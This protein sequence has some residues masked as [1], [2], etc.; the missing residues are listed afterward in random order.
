MGVSENVDI[1]VNADSIAA[2]KLFLDLVEGF[3]AIGGASQRSSSNIGNAFSKAASDVGKFTLGM[4]GAQSVTQILSTAV[5]R[6]NA[7]WDNFIQRADKAATSQTKFADAERQMANVLGDM[8]RKQAGERAISI[9]RKSGIDPY[10]VAI[11]ASSALSGKGE[12][13]P[14][15]YAF[16]AIQEAAEYM[17]G[18]R[19]QA[20]SLSG[21]ASAIL[22]VQKDDPTLSSKEAMA[23]ISNVMRADRSEKI[24][25]LSTY[26]LPSI[27]RARGYGSGKDDLSFLASMGTAIGQRA[28]DPTGQTTST[29]MEVFLKQV[30]L[31]TLPHVG[32]D[33]SVKQQYD[34]LMDTNEGRKIR[35]ELL[36]GL[37]GGSAPAELK[38]ESS[39]ASQI[40][41]KLLG[42]DVDL[43][44]G[45]GRML[46]PLT[47]LLQD[48]DNLTKRTFRANLQSIPSPHDP[49]NLTAYQR[50]QQENATNV[51]QQTANLEQA[52]SG[53]QGT[54]TL[55][56]DVLGARGQFRKQVPEIL[57]QAGV[58]DT[59]RKAVMTAFDYRSATSENREQIVE[60]GKT[61]L[62]TGI[63]RP[64]YSYEL[65][66][67]LPL[68]AEQKQ[69]NQYLKELI[70]LLDKQKNQPVPLII[71]DGDESKRGTLA[72]DRAGR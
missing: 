37:F 29:A 63:A 60:A 30:K 36:G 27:V 58:S 70:Q 54:L 62:E 17:P 72:V 31:K 10:Q 57:Q 68:T 65:S 33:A 11:A 52:L 34:F 32:R 71:Q 9:A 15:E 55:P 69:T 2:R 38:K 47:E 59:V 53:T 67:E 14:D 44:T 22:M 46:I 43:K 13:L 41:K 61:A 20:Q 3:N 51:Y 6:L 49:R 26:L 21:L 18:P 66:E 56:D 16:S 64:K 28:E 5:G 25:D 1:R 40:S 24:E 8:D 7:E 39:L 12:T 35:Q 50:M 48:E 23:F 45:K 42:E 19:T 4:M